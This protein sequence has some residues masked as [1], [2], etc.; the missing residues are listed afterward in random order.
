MNRFKQGLAAVAAIGALSMAGTA[1]AAFLLNDWQ[2]DF[3]VIVPGA[4]PVGGTS[5]ISGIDFIGFNDSPLNVTWNDSDGTTGWSIG[6]T[7]TV[8]TRGFA[9]G[10]GDSV[11]GAVPAPLLNVNGTFAGLRGYELTYD[12]SLTI[13]ITGGTAATPIWTHVANPAD[14]LTFYIDDLSD[15]GKATPGTGAGYTDGVKVLTF[16][17]VAGDGGSAN[18]A[19]T[20]DGSDDA[21]FVL[22]DVWVPGVFKTLAGEELAPGLMIGL[23][24][25]NFDLD[26]DNDGVLNETRGGFG[27]TTT[28]QSVFFFCGVEDGTFRLATAVPAPATLGLLGAGLLGLA[29][30]GR[31]RKA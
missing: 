29:A 24:D 27:C 6:D 8:L 16:T 31:R 15:G 5:A 18:V 3:G 9:S 1:N 7:Y 25:S 28:N 22:T 13:Q 21:S 17:S 14:F 26:S 20:L 11:S 30:M 12:A 23:V 2:I 19:G 4:D 10:F